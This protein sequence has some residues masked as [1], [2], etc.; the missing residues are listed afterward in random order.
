M[1]AR[2][3]HDPNMR[4][5][6]LLDAI[7]TL[8]CQ[9]QIENCCEG[10]TTS[11]PCH[12]NFSIHGKG[13]SLKAHDCFTAAGCRSC[14]REVDQGHRFSREE[15]IEMWRRAFEKTLLLLWQRGLLE[16]R[17]RGGLW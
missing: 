5:R 6:A 14:H 11:D 2:K 12:S 3:T 13:G 8:P 10:G 9:F 15:R 16:V 7:K 1:T 4:C 17:L